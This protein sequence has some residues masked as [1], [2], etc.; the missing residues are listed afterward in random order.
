MYVHINLLNLLYIYI[1][2]Y[3]YN[4][5]YIY[6]CLVRLR[7]PVLLWRTLVRGL[8]HLLFYFYFF[9]V[10]LLVWRTL[11]RGLVR[12]MRVFVR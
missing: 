10:H 8:A 2:I 4:V 7:M 5:I 3:I 12:G 11:V 1:Y 6:T 9:L